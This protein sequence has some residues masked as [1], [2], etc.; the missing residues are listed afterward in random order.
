MYTPSQFAERVRRLDQDHPNMGSHRGFSTKRTITNRRYYT[1]EDRAL[2]LGL[3]RMQ[4][5]RRTVAYF[6]VSSQAQQPDLQNQKAALQEY[7]EQSGIQVDEWIM[8]VGGGLNFERKLF[9]KLVDAILAGEVSCV[10]LAHQD[11]LASPSAISCW[12]ISAC[13]VG[14]E[15]VVMNTE[16]LSPEQ[17]LVQDLITITHC[18]SSRLSGLRNYRQA[19]SKA[20]KHNQSTQDQ[21]HPTPEQAHYFA[22]AAGTSRFVFNWALTEWK[23]QYEAGGSSIPRLPSKS[24]S[25]R[26]AKNSFPGRA[27]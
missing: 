21:L 13:P 20:L 27:R 24:S 16:T 26:F 7:C 8:E 18:F 11:R 23:T 3:P 10:V 1:D 9:L 22:R 19:L 6:R 17:E 2:A 4:K 12:C 14:S 5:D 25:T 15:L